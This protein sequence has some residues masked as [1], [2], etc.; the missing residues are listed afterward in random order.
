MRYTQRQLGEALVKAALSEWERPVLDI[1]EGKEDHRDHITRYFT[2]VTNE[3]GGSW[4]W[5]LTARHPNNEPKYIEKTAS[6][7]YEEWCGLFVAFCVQNL[8][9][10]HIEDDK[11]VPLTIKPG[12]AYYVL[13]GTHRIYDSDK[14]KEAEVKE[15]MR[16]KP[17]QARPG[18]IFT[19]GDGPTGT[20]IG[21]VRTKPENGTF[22]TV[23]GNAYGTLGDGR[24]GE[25]VVTK[26]CNVDDVKQLVR[27]D[28]D[29]YTMHEVEEDE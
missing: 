26:E 15:P 4:R 11:C 2:E 19:V 25:G 12:I 1:Q 17:E 24:Y 7:E 6:G 21:I 3:N 8:I 13:P 5:F 16:P 23:E 27:L 10:Y 20:H 14:W 22:K 18:D 29:H 28:M 9:G